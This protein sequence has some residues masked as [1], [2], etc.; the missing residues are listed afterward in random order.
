VILVLALIQAA[1]APAASPP[2]AP[3]DTIIV[4]A[5]MREQVRFSMRRDRRT[6]TGRCR[7]TRTS[8][9]ADWDELVCAAVVE[10]MGTERVSTEEFETCLESRLNEDDN[11]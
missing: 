4:T 10:C 2:P 8:D 11:D 1:V 3:E 6:G 9:N 5:Q 7:I